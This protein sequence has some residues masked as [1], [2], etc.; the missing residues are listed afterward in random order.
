M[1][2]LTIKE[3]SK[4]RLHFS[5]AL[6][7]GATVDSNFGGTPASLTIG[8][9][10]L[11]AGFEKILM[12]LSAGDQKHQPVAPAEAFGMPNPA[13]IQRVP[14]GSFDSAIKLEEG[15]VVSFADAAGNELPG[16]VQRFDEECVTID[17]NHPLAG[18][19]LLFKVQIV[20][21]G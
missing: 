5:L 1:A 15:L 3:G 21:V 17:F 2:N 6:E 14:R 16:V 19:N 8:D 20:D 13:N 7:D 4:V 18:R 10:R 11:P 9:G 12:G